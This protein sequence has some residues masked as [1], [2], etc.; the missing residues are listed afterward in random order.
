MYRRGKGVQRDTTKAYELFDQ[1]AKGGH[2]FAKRDFALMLLYGHQGFAQI[3]SGMALLFRCLLDGIS[4]A[5]KS[6]PDDQMKI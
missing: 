2:I 5:S 4:A 6:D 1:A 3:F